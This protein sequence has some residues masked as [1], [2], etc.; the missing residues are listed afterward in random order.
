MRLCAQRAAGSE[1]SVRCEPNGLAGCD[2]L[3]LYC[4]AVPGMVTPEWM[5]PPLHGQQV[6]GCPHLNSY[7]F[8]PLGFIPL[9]DEHGRFLPLQVEH[10]F[11]I[12]KWIFS[13]C[14]ILYGGMYM[15]VGFYQL[16]WW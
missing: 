13:L 1:Y 9:V 5:T 8:P 3:L 16:P 6:A 15:A 14:E 2:G 11:L 7:K 12:A 10:F 4:W